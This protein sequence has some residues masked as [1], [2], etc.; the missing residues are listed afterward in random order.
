M[1]YLNYVQQLIYNAVV[2]IQAV[3][4]TVV[5]DIDGLIDAAVTAL[6]AYI[7]AAVLSIVGGDGDTLETL[8]DQIDGIASVS[9]SA[10]KTVT[11]ANTSGTVNIFTVTGWVQAKIFARCKTVVASAG[12]CNALLMLTAGAT[13]IPNT[14]LTTLTGGELWYDITPTTVSDLIND[15]CFPYN[16][17]QSID[18][19]LSAQADSGVMEFYVEYTPMSSDGAVVAA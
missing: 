7:D 15:S 3:T 11:F 16:I 4:D 13:L 19:V 8:S 17:S 12:G 9:S 18:M 2:A 5:S 6:E 10:R 1:L 14:D